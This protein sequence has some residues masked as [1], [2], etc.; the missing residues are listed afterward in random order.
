M[1]RTVIGI[2]A[3][4]SICQLA[5]QISCVPARQD[6]SSGD[7]VRGGARDWPRLPLEPQRSPGGRTSVLP[8]PP[9][10]PPLFRTRLLSAAQQLLPVERFA[11]PL[12]RRQYM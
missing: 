2:I 1:H 3:R 6:F 12:R 8:P 11:P 7:F 9:P 5:A 10:R 4:R